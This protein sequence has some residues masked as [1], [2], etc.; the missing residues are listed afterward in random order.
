MKKNTSSTPIENR[1]R[2]VVNDVQVARTIEIDAAPNV[3]SH[4]AETK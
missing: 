3:T 2:Q 1:R 4:R